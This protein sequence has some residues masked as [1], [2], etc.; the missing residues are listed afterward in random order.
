[1]NVVICSA[2]DED[3]SRFG[4]PPVHSL[5]KK[6]KSPLAR[7]WIKR[8]EY[9]LPDG[10]TA[11]EKEDGKAGI[12]NAAGHRCPLIDSVYSGSS[13]GRPILIDRDL[14]GEKQVIYLSKVCDLTL[15]ML[16]KVGG[17]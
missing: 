1:M 6:P 13:E 12:Y 16:K 8:A 11:V 10:Y 9:R 17:S 5:Q 4:I 14:P 2:Q 15:E 3:A 7:A